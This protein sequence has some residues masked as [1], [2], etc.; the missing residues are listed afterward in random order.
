LFDTNYIL[1]ATQYKRTYL[2]KNSLNHQTM[3]G[4]SIF[5]NSRKNQSVHFSVRGKTTAIFLLPVSSWLNWSR[6]K[7]N[8]L[9]QAYHPCHIT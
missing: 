1:Y 2:S 8:M 3:C 5:T 9:I 7:D 4:Y 6:D